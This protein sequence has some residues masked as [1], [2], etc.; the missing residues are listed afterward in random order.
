MRVGFEDYNDFLMSLNITQM[1]STA[2]FDIYFVV[3][4]EKFPSLS[5]AKEGWTAKQY[6]VFKNVER[7]YR[8]KKYKI[9]LKNQII[10]NSMDM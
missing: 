1:E 8:E 9:S 5:N 10:T 7:P 4:S 3:I 2:K 6:G